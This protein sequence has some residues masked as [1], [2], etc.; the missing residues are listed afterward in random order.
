[1]TF[2]TAISVLI[3]VISDKTGY[4]LAVSTVMLSVLSTMISFAISL[5][6]S[7]AIERFNEGRRAWSS[8]GLASRNLAFLIWLHVPQTTL[9]AKEVA[10]L[11]SA[12][13]MTAEREDRER[14]K[15]LIEK[16]T[17]INLIEAFA[18]A[19]KHY[20]R[21]EGGIYYEDVRGRLV[22]CLPPGGGAAEGPS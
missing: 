11:T 20:L 6:T 4:E 22:R 3:V 13:E 8:I 5:R 17:I 9:T 10:D 16:R 14:M 21:G 2:F 15:G 18:V 7:S 19:S 1:M 12:G